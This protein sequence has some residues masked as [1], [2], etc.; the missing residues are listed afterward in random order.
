MKPRP[1]QTDIINGAIDLWGQGHRRIAG[2]LATGGGKTPILSWIAEMCVAAGR[3][4]LVLAHRTELIAQAIGK[5]NDVAPHRRVGRMQGRRWREYRAEVVVG[6][7]QTCSTDTALALLS[8]RQWGLIVVDETHH[9]T[10]ATY[11]KILNV[12]GAMADDGPLVLG[13]TATLGRTDGAS[14]GQVFQEVIEPRVGLLDLIRHP[15]GPFLVPPRGI[16]IKIDDLDLDKVRYTGGDFS[17]GA[18]GRAMSAA[19]A[20]KRI[21]EGWQEHARGRQTIAFLPSV[22]ISQEVAETFT[23]HGIPAVHLAG[24]TPDDRREQTL[25]EYRQGRIKILCN[26]DLF[27][28]GTDL[29]ATS[30]IV[31]GAPTSST[32]KYQQQVGRGL[33]LHPGKRDCVVLDFAGSSTRHRLATMAS[34]AGA[35]APED[36]PDDL[37]I[38]EI[39]ETAGHDAYEEGARADSTTDIE[40]ADGNLTHEL[41]DLF[42]AS[43]AAWL[44]TTGGSWFVPAGAAGYLFLRAV[45]GDRY[46]LMGVTPGG[47]MHELRHDMEIGYAMAAGEE[48]V[49]ANPIWQA[50]RDAAWRTDKRDARAVQRASALIDR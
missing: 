24:T 10:A 47:Q 38:Y 5:L 9:I 7:V 12:L 36:T 28:E 30:C 41:I 46:N 4:V 49:A 42:G 14:L 37:L 29:P 22:A 32:G 39:D 25:E 21:V 27:T 1:Y 26:V 6:S 3:P 48:L 2:V 34:L 40:Y 50:H 16:R 17:G 43:H 45:H 13:M 8:M 31:L 20:P 18:L 44:R 19:M 33:R 15:D 23:A 11:M 35:D